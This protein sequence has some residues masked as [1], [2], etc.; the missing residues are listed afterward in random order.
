ME[1]ENQPH[2]MKLTTIHVGAIAL[3]AAL[4]LTQSTD[5]Q[6]LL[7][8]TQRTVYE[9]S[10]PFPMACPS[11]TGTL[12][13]TTMTQG[14]SACQTLGFST[15]HPYGGVAINKFTSL[16]WAS[17]GF[18]ITEYDADGIPL[19][20]FPAPT[21]SGAVSG[22]G[23]DTAGGV[24]WVADLFS[25]SVMGIIPPPPPGCTAQPTVVFP[26]VTVP[27]IAAIVTGVTWDETT[28]S[29]FVCYDDGQVAN[30]MTDGSVGP[31]GSP[32]PT[33]CPLA[34]AAG[35]TIDSAASVTE[36]VPI[37]TVVDVFGD[38]TYQDA[39]GN[40]AP[41]TAYTPVACDTLP[42]AMLNGCAFSSGGT[43]YGV[44]GDTLG[45][46]PPT[47]QTFHQCISP[48]PLFEVRVSGTPPGATAILYATDAGPMICPPVVVIGLPIY[49]LPTTLLTPG[50]VVTDGAGVGILNAPI[51]PGLPVG[52]RVNAQFL[53]L[54]PGQLQVTEGVHLTIMHN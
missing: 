13:N 9:T 50:V 15:G 2:T 49:F 1:E 52:R 10:G 35:I 26:A 48:N 21:P 39:L 4:S 34:T 38:Y 20:T 16:V 40:A 27:A 41:V 51:P 24:L 36:N 43:R 8:H 33:P 25:R 47:I 42:V 32:V 18:D 14:T 44:G 17:D 53:V 46:I 7:T 45:G 29:L 31:Y 30:I 28:G 11:P 5:A 12:L 19:R 23:W 22:L 6:T 37:F 54:A 3:A